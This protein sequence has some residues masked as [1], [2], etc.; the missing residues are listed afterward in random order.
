MVTVQVPFCLVSQ[1]CG[2][3]GNRDTHFRLRCVRHGSRVRGDPIVPREAV[4]ESEARVCSLSDMARLLLVEGLEISNGV[5]ARGSAGD[6]TKDIQAFEVGDE[7]FD[8]RIAGHT[9]AG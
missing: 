5:W 7:K 9:P 1:G 8:F 4:G 2:M 3:R 6:S